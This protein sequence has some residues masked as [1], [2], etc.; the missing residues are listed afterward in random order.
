[1]GALARLQAAQGNPVVTARLDVFYLQPGL[2]RELALLLD[3]TR[4]VEG[5]LIDLSARMRPHDL[6]A[7]NSVNVHRTLQVLAANGLLIG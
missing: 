2:M 1:M 5:L 3:G 6:K 7:L 4:D